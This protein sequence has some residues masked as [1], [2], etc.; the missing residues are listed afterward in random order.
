MATRPKPKQ[1]ETKR[2]PFPTRYGLTC[3][4]ALEVEKLAKAEAKQVGI[5]ESA[6]DYPHV[7]ARAFDLGIAAAWRELRGEP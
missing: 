1:K 2:F 5:A 7:M 4:Q 3:Q 6:I